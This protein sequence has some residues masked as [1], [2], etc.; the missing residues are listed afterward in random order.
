MNC[1]NRNSRPGFYK[2][3]VNVLGPDGRPL[4]PRDPV[5]VNR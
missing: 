2:Y 1:P 5:I 4:E 3:T